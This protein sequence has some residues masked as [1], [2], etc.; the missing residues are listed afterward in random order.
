MQPESRPSGFGATTS[1]RL[2]T[3]GSDVERVLVSDAFQMRWSLSLAPSF[4]VSSLPFCE[5]TLP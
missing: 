2:Q 5:V 4:L 1:L 3:I